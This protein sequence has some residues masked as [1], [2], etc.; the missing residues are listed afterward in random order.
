M[1][2]FP[3]DLLNLVLDTK[4]VWGCMG[5]SV[6]EREGEGEGLSINL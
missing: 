3:L 6:R 5:A 4:G 2:P 1:V